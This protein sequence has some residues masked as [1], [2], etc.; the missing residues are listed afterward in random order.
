MAGTH[1]FSVPNEDEARRLV[2]ALARHG[3][4]HV[5]AWP[6]RYGDGWL[7]SAVDEGPYPVSSVGDRQIAAV[8]RAAALVA[9]EYDGYSVG[10][11]RFDVSSLPLSRPS[12][13]ISVTNPGA[14]PPAPEVS[15]VERP[16]IGEL[17]FEPDHFELAPADLSGLD[18]V[19]WAALGHAHGSAD[20]IPDLIRALAGDEDWDDLVDELMGDDLLHQGSCYS[21]TAPAIPFLVELI[22]S[23]EVSRR[24]HLYVD[25]LAAAGRWGDSLVTDASRAYVQH[26]D[27]RPDEWT[28]EVNAAVGQSLPRLLARWDDEIPA[29]RF[30]LAALAGL[31]PQHG[32]SVA[33]RVAAMAD[34]LHDTAHGACLDLAQALMSGRD[35]DIRRLAA[36]ISV[37]LD[38]LHSLDIPAIEE[39]LSVAV[40]GGHVLAQATMEIMPDPTR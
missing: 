28:A 5:A 17:P 9:R 10:G 21:A 26:R 38:G 34:E 31:F 11:S 24:L 19:P 6:A 25:L 13:P 40:I 29:V 14:R 8:A 3:F 7:V 15:V 18:D 1:N 33:D 35:E 37:W 36:D 4:P 16:P 39:N 23:L 27:V 22:G 30:V 20:D 2:D 32:L 12:G